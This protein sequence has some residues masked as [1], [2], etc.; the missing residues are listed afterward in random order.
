MVVVAALLLIPPVAP[1][2]DPA[3][4]AQVTDT[5][6]CPL[7][8]NQF[9]LVYITDPANGSAF[10]MVASN[11]G[12]FYGNIFYT[13]TP[14]AAFSLTITLP[15][16]FI[17][18]GARPI[19]TSSSF[20]LLSGCFSPSFDNPDGISISTAGGHLSTSGYPVVLLSDYSSQTLG[21]T[22]TITVTGTVPS[23][24]L[25]YVTVHMA[26]GLK[27][28]DFSKGTQTCPTATGV[29]TPTAVITCPQ[30]YTFSA[31]GTSF[32]ASTTITSINTFKKDPGFA[33]VVTD[34]N[35]NPVANVTVQIHDSS[36]NLLG[37]ATTDEDG[38]YLFAYKYTGSRAQFTVNL[39]DFGLS[40]TI[41]LQANKIA[42]VNFQIQKV[43]VTM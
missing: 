6:F 20:S 18:Q 40:Q 16:P 3:S 13:A 30:P 15:Y 39:P 7:T 41:T 33:G 42:L 4:P 38:V 21:S 31:I 32:S 26:Y 27:G 37:T 10:R 1:A 14:S 11:P 2:Q 34:L 8:S 29:T 12:Q 9:I 25:V 28:Q 36:G 17:T 35:S 19:Q 23:T 22:T 43:L 5:S 24:G